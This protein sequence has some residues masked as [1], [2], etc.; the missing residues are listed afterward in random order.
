ML[1]VPMLWHC[2]WQR[3]GLYTL[4]L[5]TQKKPVVFPRCGTS[6]DGELGIVFRKKYW[7]SYGNTKATVLGKCE[8]TGLI[9][10]NEPTKGM[11]PLVTQHHLH[12]L[13]TCYKIPSWRSTEACQFIFVRANSCIQYQK[14][15][16]RTLTQTAMEVWQPWNFL[17]L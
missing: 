8:K 7:R 2:R 15:G 17:H 14:Y 10:R 13:S 9:T 11:F 5:W 6:C 1:P 4:W 12:P 16:G 3:G